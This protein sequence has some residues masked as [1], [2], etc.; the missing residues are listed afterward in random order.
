MTNPIF[1]KTE[2]GREEIATRKYH[3]PSRLRTLLLLIDGKHEIDDI[4]GKV[5]GIGLTQESITELLHSGFIQA[6]GMPSP[7]AEHTAEEASS[8]SLKEP[9]PKAPNLHAGK[10]LPNGDNQFEAIYH[11]YNETIKSTIGL[12]G[13]LLQ[14]KVERAGSINE[15]RDLRNPYLEAVLKAKGHEMALSLAARLDGLLY[16]GEEIPSLPPIPGL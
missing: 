8:Y 13:Y 4:L 11:F 16:F 9:A 12:R 15:F 14:L 2:K 3:L 1:D 6:V 5:A 10:I 7:M